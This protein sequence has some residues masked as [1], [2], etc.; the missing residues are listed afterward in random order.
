MAGLTTGN[1]ANIHGCTEGN[2]PFGV[3]KKRAASIID[4]VQQR[5]CRRDGQAKL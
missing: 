2:G 5:P 3:W 1:Q 4:A